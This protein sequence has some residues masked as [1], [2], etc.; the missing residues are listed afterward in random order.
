MILISEHGVYF[1][2]NVENTTIPLSKKPKISI[3]NKGLCRA[4]CIIHEVFNAI[5]SNSDMGSSVSTIIY[6]PSMTLICERN[7]LHCISV[8]AL[9]IS[10]MIDHVIS[11]VQNN[12]I[13]WLETIAKKKE[14]KMY[15]YHHTNN[16][17]Q[18]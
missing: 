9:C 17:Q 11:D 1:K 16:D 4:L 8:L 15:H 7:S 5:S 12:I 18:V 14:F 6:S 13:M 2:E 3:V 10:N